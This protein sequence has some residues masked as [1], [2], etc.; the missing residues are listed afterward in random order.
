MSAV[1]V[2]LTFKDFADTEI[3]LG[4]D[5]PDLVKL[6]GLLD[7]CLRLT[8]GLLGLL[9][10]LLPA[11]DNNLSWFGFLLWLLVLLCGDSFYFLN[12]L[13]FNG[14]GHIVHCRISVLCI[15]LRER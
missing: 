8:L 4:I 14:R 3:T 7:W 11:F 1:R 5:L 9:R 2:R 10:L 13:L 15:E 6:G 12:F